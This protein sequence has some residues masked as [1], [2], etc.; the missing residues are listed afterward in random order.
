M[1][2]RPDRHRRGRILG[3]GLLAAAL[4]GAFGCEQTPKALIESA[5]ARWKQGDYLGA[6]KT[7]EHLIEEYPKSGQAAD[8]HYAIGTIEYLY[9]NNYTRAVEAFRRVAADHPTEPL[10][11]QAQRTLA[12]IYETKFHDPR[13]AVAEYQKLLLNAR[14]P[15]LTEEIQY[16]IGEVYFAEGDYDQARHEWTQLTAQ[17]PEG[18]WADNAYYRIGATYFLQQQYD[19]ALAVFEDTAKRYPD[20]DVGA[21][22]EF[23]AANALVELERYPEALKIYR[24]LEDSY[25]NRQVITL[26]IISVQSRLSPTPD[27][28]PVPR[29]HPASP[30]PRR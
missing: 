27:H 24:S 12:E 13:K 29:G 6:V 9:L 7:Y 14:D 28:L 21:E 22:M 1:E 16:R 15:A 10:G 20:S 19:R 5:D 25:P 26:K 4:A 2:N 8:A 3:L 30:S 11:L 17:S 23:W 18:I